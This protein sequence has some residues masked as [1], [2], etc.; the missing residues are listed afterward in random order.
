MEDSGTSKVTG[1]RQIVRLKEL[2]QRWQSVTLAPRWSNISCEQTQSGISPAVSRRIRSTTSYCDSD[3]DG[4]QSPDPPHDVPKGYLAVYVGPEHRRFIIP[5]SYLSHQ[6]FKVLLEK[7]EEEFGFDHC[8]GLT[9]PCE[10]ET[11]KYLLKCME[12]RQNDQPTAAD[13]TAGTSSTIEE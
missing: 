6:L 11:F 3:D 5:T 1:I 8:G 4:C 13:S 2:L 7:A 10:I 12:T 9:L